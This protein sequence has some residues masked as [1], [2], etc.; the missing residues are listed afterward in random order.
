MKRR[1]ITLLLLISAVAVGRGKDADGRL[2]EF[3]AT[4]PW[5][6]VRESDLGRLKKGDRLP[7]VI[8]KLGLPSPCEVNLPFLIYQAADHP[9]KYYIVYFDL[10]R[11]LKLTNR[12]KVLKIVLTSFSDDGSAIIDMWPEKKAEKGANQPVEPTPTAVTSPAD[13]VAAPAV[14][15]AHQ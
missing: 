13:A 5:R 14:G 15:A 9:G 11:K 2:D 1:F 8:E 6:E 10:G 3:V 12:S 4:S 7:V